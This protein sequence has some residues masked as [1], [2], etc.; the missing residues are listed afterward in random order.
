MTHID[1]WRGVVGWEEFYEVSPTGL[2]RN[3]TT[4]KVRKHRVEKL[5][6]CS[7]DLWNHNCMKRLKVHRMVAMAYLSNPDNKPQVNHKDGN[8]ENNSVDNLE[9]CTAKENSAHAYKKGLS[10]SVK[11]ERH[12]RVKLTDLEAYF[13]R[14]GGL[15]N[16]E[17]AKEFGVSPRLVRAIKAGH[18]WKHLPPFTKQKVTERV[19]K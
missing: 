14:Y 13:I 16:N 2:I 4:K 10:V 3:K 5:G 15:S 9:W 19:T 7:V 11:G 18:L 6:Y 1:E 17:A 8:K 12:G